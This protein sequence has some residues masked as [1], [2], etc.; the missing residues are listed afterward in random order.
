MPLL[1]TIASKSS[2]L[3]L[4]PFIGEDGLLRVGGRLT[5][6]P[7]PFN[8]KHPIILASHPFVSLIFQQAHLQALYAGTQLT[9]ITL[10]QQFWLLRARNLVRSIIY[11]CITCVRERA[12][13]PHQLM[14]NLPSLRVSPSTWSFLHCG[15]DYAG[16][17]QIRASGGRGIT[18][19]K[20]YIA[21]FICLSTRAIHLEL[22]GNYSTP[23]FLDAFT[24][25]CS[26]RRLPE[27]MYSDNPREWK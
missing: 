13:Q 2:L 20:A 7:I 16:P 1:L 22:V 4:N 23:A 9:I 18:A 25:F 5:N 14:G 19:R 12:A 3:S 26:R 27:F 10:R 24:R 15:L 17:I 11:K 21:L 6:A 8:A